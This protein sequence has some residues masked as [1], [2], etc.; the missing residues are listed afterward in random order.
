MLTQRSVVNSSIAHRPPKRPVP[1][2]FVPPKAVL[3]SSFSGES[4][5]C[6]RSASGG[7][8]AAAAAAALS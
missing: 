7:D 3:A 4:F 8:Y 2:S 1:E 5:T 6:G